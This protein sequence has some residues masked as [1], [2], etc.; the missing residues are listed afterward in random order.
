MRKLGFVD[1]YKS[2][3][4][5]C[6]L[7]KKCANGKFTSFGQC[8]KGLLIV[9]ECPT[10]AE[11]ATGNSSVGK[12]Y[13]FLTSELR[14]CGLSL[15][16]DCM[17]VHAVRCRKPFKKGQADYSEVEIS[18]CY[19]YLLG[20][21]EKVKPKVVLTLGSTGLKGLLK[22]EFSDTS[23]G[24]WHGLSIQYT[25][26]KNHR[27]WLV[28]TFSPS[29]SSDNREDIYKPI[30]E[31]EIKRAV[32]LLKKELPP[33][34]H[35]NVVHLLNVKD[36]VKALRKA[37]KALYVSLDYETTGKK[38]D[39]EEHRIATVSITSIYKEASED[40][41]DDDNAET[42]SFPL[43]YLGVFDDDEQAT[44]AEE[45]VE[46]LS[47]CGK[48]IAHNAKFEHRWSSV[49]LGFDFPKDRT[50]CTMITSHLMDERKKFCSLKFQTYLHFGLS[51]YSKNI[52]K[53]LESVEDS[54]GNAFNT[55]D[56]APLP[57]LLEYNGFDTYF[58]YLL[59]KVQMKYWKKTKHLDKG[60]GALFQRGCVSLG[61]AENEGFFL[62]DGYFEENTK[63]IREEIATLKDELLKSREAVL[64]KKKT[65]R[66]FEFGKDKDLDIMLYDIIG[67]TLDKTTDS[68]NRS[69][70]A[71]VML[72]MKHEWP[73][74]YLAI[75]K[76][77]K[78]ESTYFGQI[79]REA[80]YGKL[81]TNYNLHTTRTGRS[82]IAKG[83]MIEVVRD[84]SKNPE[85]IPIEDVNP[86]D[87]VYCYDDAC[88]LTIKKVLWSGRTGTKEVVKV[89]WKSHGGRVKGHVK[90]T[91]EH[92]IRM[93]NGEYVEARNINL[94]GDY[95]KKGSSK[96][97]PKVRALALLRT[98]DLEKLYVTGRNEEPIMDHRFVYEHLVGNLEDSD[99][100]HH[101]DFNHKNNVPQNLLRMS[102][103][104]HH[105]LHGQWLTEDQR[106]KKIQFLQKAWQ[107]AKLM[108]KK[109]GEECHNFIKFTRV[110]LVRAFFRA[111]GQLTAMPYDFQVIKDK[112]RYYNLDLT[113]LRERFSRRGFYITRGMMIRCAHFPI[114]KI[115]R[116]L[117]IG[118]P[119]VRAL[120]DSRGIKLKCPGK[121]R[122][123]HNHII[124]RI[125]RTKEVCDV[126]DLEVEDCH[127][128]IAG[129]ICVHNSSSSPNWQN[130]P[131]R[132]PIARM[133]VRKGICAPEG[134]H[135]FEADYGS[136]EVRIA[137]CYT[138]DP[139][140]IGYILDPTTDMH[141]D[142]ALD[143]FKMSLKEFN[144]LDKKMGKMIRFHAKN[145]F[146]FANFY[147]SSFKS[148]AKTLW[149]VAPDL[150]VDEA[151]SMLDH[152][153]YKGF[154][155]Y[156]DYEEHIK[157]VVNKFWKKFHIFRRW[158]QENMEFYKKNL[159]IENYLGFRRHGP[160]TRNEIGNTAI[161]GTAFMCLLWAFDQ[162]ND[163]QN[164]EGWKS[165][166]RGQI[167]D[168]IVGSVHPDEK[169]HVFSTIK[170]VM[171]VK[172]LEH[173]PW[174][175]VPMVAEFEMSPINGSWDDLAEVKV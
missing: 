116:T 79:N 93:L 37:R 59:Y 152:L 156:E 76:R 111:G 142:S 65:G 153:Y 48:I 138:K 54:S 106:A 144:S 13:E 154:R 127:N 143:I 90:M 172:L 104:C 75:A 168:S 3:C 115:A 29:T 113:V 80:I 61:D 24:R 46:T 160:L 30:I 149:K 173:F 83:T 86:G 35:P 32:N 11:T 167:H 147:G 23:I 70:D 19:P 64:F 15:E 98:T 96:H 42:I 100:I 69:K 95:R 17:V 164:K 89:F 133:Y 123:F 41:Y 68:G 105:S 119:K 56:K 107:K 43:S 5:I 101:K 158:Q 132:D 73:T 87:Y 4:L 78:V 131:K 169:D 161:Q 57:E 40:P 74:K 139:K 60:V 44:I 175:N 102:K 34:K 53:Y 103:T 16:K 135:L 63:N 170:E 92:R 47:R 52:H 12:T 33:E 50:Y 145:G 66:N 124:Y 77:E 7:D 21:L 174:I 49:L 129:G 14:K 162:L 110:G 148:C 112:F 31:L 27:C 28:P 38:P 10:N 85:G 120:Y 118:Y 171:E 6:G 39:H 94:R 84:L 58:T 9:L 125:E 126:Y 146:V 150:P 134:E 97:S 45:L 67:V 136:L 26:E 141:R 140:L 128:F 117:G 151:S 88:N 25:T 81:H 2:K 109:R 82:C 108:P 137:A 157:E 121:G 71:E 166:L 159:Y 55:V 99:V 51:D 91:P 165:R 18:S 130:L 36:I 72:S 20:Q 155:T 1:P 8:Q 163:I 62:V 114:H 22:K 122:V